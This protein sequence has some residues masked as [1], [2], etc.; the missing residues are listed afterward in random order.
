MKVVGPAFK[1]IAAKYPPTD[2]NIDKLSDKVIKG[3]SGSW[4]DIAM[5]PHASLSKADAKTIVTYILSLKK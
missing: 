4:G 5:T 2:A 3:G 1:D